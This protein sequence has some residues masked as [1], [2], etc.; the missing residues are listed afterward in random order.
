MATLLP[1]VI[2]VPGKGIPPY[3]PGLKPMRGPLGR[4]RDAV[5]WKVMSRV[6]GK[7]MLPGLNRLRRQH[8]LRELTSPLEVFQPPYQLIA[9]T[10]EPLEYHR[11]DLPPTAHLVGSQPWDGPA[12][13][14]AWLDEPGDPWVLVTC[15]TDYQGDEDLARVAAE[16][17]RD[18]PVRVLLTLGEAYGKAALPEAA[19]VTAVPFVPHGPAMERATVVVTHT[20]M[21]TVGKAALAGVPIVAVPFGRDQP[22]IARRIVEAGLGVAMPAAKLTPERL[23]D[24]VRR[25]GS[26]RPRAEAVA[27]RLRRTD[28]AARFADAVDE[29]V[30]SAVPTPVR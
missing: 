8:G 16:A 9:L 29:L 15:S 26:A 17:L 13:R 22:E 2:P 4:L 21:G 14:P 30:P 11:T 5:G 1:T 24:A 12:E 10:A 3:G 7:A 27:A 19:N 6:F 23:R 20:G 18:E 28:A 25:A